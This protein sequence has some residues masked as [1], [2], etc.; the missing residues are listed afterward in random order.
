MALVMLVILLKHFVIITQ[1]STVT[2]MP[3]VLLSQNMSCIVTDNL[4]PISAV[5][6]PEFILLFGF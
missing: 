5:S 1:R 4:T 2:R 6:V 3:I